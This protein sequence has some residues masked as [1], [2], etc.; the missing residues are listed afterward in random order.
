MPLLADPV[1]SIPDYVPDENRT[2]GWAALDWTWQWLQQPDGP[3]AGDP[4]SFTDEQTR[5]VLRW[6]EINDLGRFVHRRGVL[7]R[8]KGWGKDPFMAA[9]AAVEL[10]GPCRFGGWAA[11][12]FPIAVQHPAPWIQ[13]AAVSQ[14]QTRNTMTLFPGLFTGA[15]LKEFRIDLGKT[16]IYARGTGRIEAVTSSP[17]A[18]EGGRPSLAIVNESQEWL[19]NN[20][21]VAM[22]KAIRRNLAKSNDGSARSMEICNAHLPGEESVAEETYEAWKQADGDV[23][24]LYYDAVE[25]PVVPD[26]TDLHALRQALL[27]ARGDSL[28]LNVDRLIEEIADPVTPEWMS[29]R[30]YLNQVVA[31]ESE[32]WMPMNLWDERARPEPIPTGA[33]V[34]LAFDGS[35][36]GDSTGLLAVSL[37]DSPHIELVRVW[38]KTAGDPEWRVPI[39]DVEDEIRAAC[40]RFRVREIVADTYRWAR[41]MQIL[42]AERLPV[43]EFPQR[44]ARMIPATTRLHEAVCNA[45]MTHDASEPLR[46]H[47]SNAVLKISSQGGH[48]TK[49]HKSSPRRIDLAVCAVMGFERACMAVP[50]RPQVIDLNA[51][52]AAE[53]QPEGSQ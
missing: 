13:V 17:S 51:L 1:R 18:L 46:R 42:E 41:S 29:R 44:P 47:V 49:D 11:D 30:Y 26:L 50:R 28:W 32:R 19:L 2:L 16:I 4:W 3:D 33:D 20:D 22:S 35:F 40:K 7:R 24:G 21:G 6:Y 43:V 10:C 31:V 25:A 45:G 14:D 39:E 34:V 9:I 12:G 37:G 48:L 5:I 27:A 23:P 36:N 15:A 53:P 52:L 38:E 8:M